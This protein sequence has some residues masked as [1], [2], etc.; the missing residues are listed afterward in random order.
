MAIRKLC[1]DRGCD[2]LAIIG[3]R[4][5]PDHDAERRA[6][7]ARRSAELKQ[8]PEQI[9]SRK[10]MASARWKRASALFLQRHRLCVDCAELGGVS[11]ATQVDHIIRH[12]NDLTLFWDRGNWQALCQRCHSRKTAGEVWHGR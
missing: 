5:C 3:A 11:V 1:A 8:T 9:Q 12:R 7:Q 10:L 6:A 4:H 2:D